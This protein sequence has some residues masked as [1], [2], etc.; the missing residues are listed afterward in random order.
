MGIIGTISKSISEALKNIGR[1][2]DVRESI[3]P[4]VN[5]GTFRAP[6]TSD[7]GLWL[8]EGRTGILNSPL[9]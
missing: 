1:S 3:V 2:W 4:H 6:I 9:P 5:H 8:G 7:G